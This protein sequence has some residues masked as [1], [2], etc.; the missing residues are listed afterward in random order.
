MIIII[1][2][3]HLYLVLVEVSHAKIICLVKHDDDPIH[4]RIYAKKLFLLLW[5]FL[6]VLKKMLS[7]Y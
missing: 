5:G 7:I 2:F 3:V 1:I 4:L 6:L